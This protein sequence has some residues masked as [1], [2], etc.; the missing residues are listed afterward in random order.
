LKGRASTVSLK[1]YFIGSLQSPF[2][3]ANLWS[4]LMR[5]KTAL[6]FSPN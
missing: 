6:D 5:T 3:F 2:V 1:N 4:V